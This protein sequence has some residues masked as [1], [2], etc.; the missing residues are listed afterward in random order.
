[1]VILFGLGAL[2]DAINVLPFWEHFGRWWPLIIIVIG[3]IVFINNYRQ[4][5]TALALI[6]IGVFLQL[7]TLDIFDVNFWALFWPVVIIA[8]GLSIV[9]NRR[10]TPKSIHTQDSDAISA[11]FG[12]S[13][14]INKSQN[15]K[16]GKATAIFGGVSIDLRDAVIKKQAT[17]EVFAL[18]GGIEL[19]VPREWKVQHQA[20]PILGGIESK[21]H[22]D[23][24]ADDAPVLI[25]VGTVALGGVDVHS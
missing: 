18:C 25:I 15:Y 12:G 23:K 7:G 21:N 1:L 8:I 10:V 24:A 20:F 19:K 6:V 16:G 9:I 22:S 2:L 5:I 3:L 17:L 14:T 4:Y 11:I 13:E